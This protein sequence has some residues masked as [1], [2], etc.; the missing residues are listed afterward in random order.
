V[1]TGLLQRLQ[2]WA[3]SELTG[4]LDAGKPPVVKKR[5]KKMERNES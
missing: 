1:W 3:W 5:D 4:A 2:A